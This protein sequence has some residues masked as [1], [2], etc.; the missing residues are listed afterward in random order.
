MKVRLRQRK[1]L[2]PQPNKFAYS[3]KAFQSA[4]LWGALMRFRAQCPIK[5]SYLIGVTRSKLQELPLMYPFT[6]IRSA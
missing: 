6:F 5:L 3:V 4:P 1:L 2:R